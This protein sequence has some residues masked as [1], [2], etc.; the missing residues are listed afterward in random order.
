M[1]ID[2]VKNRYTYLNS[3]KNIVHQEPLDRPV[4]AGRELTIHPA[5]P[6][7]LD[8]LMKERPTWRFKSEQH[9]YTNLKPRL[10]HFEIY[11]GNEQLGR[12]WVEHH[13]R[14]ETVRYFFVNPR[15]HKERDRGGAAYSTKPEVAAKR[16]LK[17][18]HLK[19]PSERAVEAGVHVRKSLND[20][21]SKAQY[22][23]RRAKNALENQLFRYAVNH[24][25]TIKHN[26]DADI[27]KLDLPALAQDNNDAVALHT[28]VDNNQGF[29]IRIEPNSTYLVSRGEY[30]HRAFND[31][32]LT[33]RLRGALGLLKLLDDNSY[34]PNV[35]MRVQSNLYFVIAEQEAAE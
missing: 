34:I 9:L 26:F 32:T 10:T 6:T 20:I 27:A 15:I 11:D 12:L 2:D 5:I 19:T 18:F 8:R 35:G 30:F 25:D 7:L 13:W 22:P 33:D 16:I 17:S 29:T 3:M 23:L 28:A 21:V 1:F 24:W 31:S 14:D 4:V